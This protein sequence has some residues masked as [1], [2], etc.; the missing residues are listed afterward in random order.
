MDLRRSMA[1]GAL[2]LVVTACASGELS[3]TEY[4]EEVNAI[5]NRASQRYEALAS[6]GRGAVLVAGGARLAEFTPHDLAEAFQEVR[7]LEAE[8]ENAIGEIEPP[9]QIADLHDLMFDFDDGFF[10]AQEAMAAR[11]RTAESWSELSASPEMEAY[12]AALAKDKRECEE[13]EAELNSI[14]EQ[15]EAFADTPWVPGELKGIFEVVLGCR[16]YPERPENTYR[17]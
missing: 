3:V 12:R 17:P 5:V 11:A 2:M 9:T 13:T 14:A 10:A 6:D 15:R 16:G 4:V 1:V 8:L 7:E